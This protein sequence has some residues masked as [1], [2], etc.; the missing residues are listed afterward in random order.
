MKVESYKNV[1]QPRFP[2][3]ELAGIRSSIKEQLHPVARVLAD[4]VVNEVLGREILLET[5]RDAALHGVRVLAAMVCVA[6]GLK[7]DE[8]QESKEKFQGTLLRTADLIAEDLV[9]EECCSAGLPVGP[10]LN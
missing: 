5:L 4:Y 9:A 6:H 10:Y 3:S 1:S 8:D 2:D 7:L